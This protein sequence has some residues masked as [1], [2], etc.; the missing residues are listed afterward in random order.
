MS[1]KKTYKKLLV[2]VGR[3]VVAE[4]WVS[5]RDFLLGLA[6][7]QAFPGPNFNCIY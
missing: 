3:Y 4:G 7:I 5:A 2:T 6:L 1:Q